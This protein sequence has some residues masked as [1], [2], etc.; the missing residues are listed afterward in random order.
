MQTNPAWL[1]LSRGL[2]Y[3]EGGPEE[4]PEQEKG[5]NMLIAMQS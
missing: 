4:G 3:L 5:N 2:L 1:P